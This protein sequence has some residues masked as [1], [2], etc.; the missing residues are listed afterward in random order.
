M[1]SHETYR[2]FSIFGDAKEHSFFE[3]L[4]LGRVLV[5]KNDRYLEKVF[6]Q[7]LLFNG[8]IRRCHQNW[9]PRLD[10]YQLTSKGDEYFRSLQISKLQRGKHTDDQLRHFRLFNREKDG[11][12][13]VAG[14]GDQI[15]EKSAKL[16][17]THP[18]LYQ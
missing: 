1:I 13:G 6:K 7:K 5:K 14:M 10:N 3:F 16:Q 4:T 15:T 8:W 9:S 11:K 2:L 18:E 17:E 12:Y